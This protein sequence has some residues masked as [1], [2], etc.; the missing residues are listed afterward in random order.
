MEEG[1][2]PLPL[3]LGQARQVA[4]ARRQFAPGTTK[5]RTKHK[6]VSFGQTVAS[7]REPSGVG[8]WICRMPNI[9]HS[10]V[11]LTRP[12]GFGNLA[13]SCGKAAAL[14]AGA[15]NGVLL[16]LRLAVCFLGLLPVGSGLMA[17][18]N[19]DTWQAWLEQAPP[20]PVWRVPKDLAAWQRERLGIRAKLNELLG[21]LPARPAAPE[22]EVISREDRGDYILEKFQFDNGAG[23]TVPG[24][25]LLPKGAPAKAPAIL[26]CHWHGG[27]YEQGKAE[28]FLAEHTPEAPGPALAQ[29]GFV[30]LAI[31]A[32]CFG[33]RNGRGPG[34]PV[35]KDGAGEMTASKFNL[36][37]GRTLWG[38]I[39][40]D[41]LMALDYLASRPEVDAARIGVMGMSMGATRSWWLMALDE[42][43]K[44]GVAVACLTRYQDLIAHEGLKHHGIY[45]FVP[46]MLN[47]FDTEAVIALIAPRPALF[48]NGDQDI[49]SP[50]SGIRAIETAVKPVYGLYDHTTA[51]QSEVYPGVGHEYL[52]EMWRKTLA[53]FD[54]HLAGQ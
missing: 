12:N 34:G 49:G 45:Y 51:F 41:D 8:G 17:Q 16:G 42:R 27:E 11:R 15:G 4:S 22:V 26:Y 24:Y 44:T 33:E 20:V 30:V 31:D 25:L 23:A 9:L 13:A 52:P 37:A 32:C 3:V 53:W 21:K 48:L 5:L 50:V 54:L 47:Y 7:I 2:W 38:M 1:R 29:R 39:L 18:S 10:G 43:I 14:L 40:R 46:G 36:W 28:L 35:E 6:P 19:H